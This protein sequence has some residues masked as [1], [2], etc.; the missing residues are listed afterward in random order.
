MKPKP[1]KIGTQ[2]RNILRKAI[3][4]Y[5]ESEGCSCCRDN[6]KH[7]FNKEVLSILL[8]VKKYDDNSGY[9]FYKYADDKAFGG[10]E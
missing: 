2:E 8:S 5:M 4:N 10:K 9:N 7:D 3:A 1:L 6:E